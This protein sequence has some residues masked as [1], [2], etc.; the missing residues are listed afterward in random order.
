MIGC[1]VQWVGKIRL[2]FAGLIFA[3]NLPGLNRPGQISQVRVVMVRLIRPK[4]IS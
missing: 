1:T 3:P 4:I 2:A